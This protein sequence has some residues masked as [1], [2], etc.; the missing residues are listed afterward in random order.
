WEDIR[1]RVG[2]EEVFFIIDNAKTHLPFRRW[3]RV[4]GITLL[5][6]RAYSPDLNPIENVWSLVK[7][8]LHKNY[9]ELYLMKGPKR[10]AHVLPL[11]WETIPEEFFEKLWKSMPNSI[12]AV[13][14]ARGGYTKY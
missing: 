12:A 6:I 7:D 3:L 13:L 5:E 2:D 14:E 4:Q 8:K 9:P 11:V 1:E 10:L